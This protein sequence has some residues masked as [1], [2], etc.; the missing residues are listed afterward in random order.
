[1]SQILRQSTAVDVLIGPFLDITDGVTAE[2]GE[3]PAIK[4]SKNGQTLGAKNDATVPVH[5]ADGYHNCELDATDTDT[6]GT[7]VLTSVGTAT[8]LPI[9]HE[10]QIIHATP[11]DSI[12]GSTPTMLTSLDVG[13]LYEGAVTTPT[14]QNSFAMDTAIVSD[15]N[16][17][18]NI[19]T[20]TDITTG[21]AV[22]RY[23]TDVVQSNDT[24]TVNAIC[25]F[26]VAA[27]DILRVESRIHPGYSTSLL[28]T[29]SALN[30]VD[31]VV[32]N[33]LST[34]ST[35]AALV[36]TESIVNLVKAKTDQLSFTSG[37]VKADIRKV[38]GGSDIQAAG[39][40]SQQ[41]GES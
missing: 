34:M 22:S 6:I 32:D 1:M 41:Y 17:I 12:Y 5:D 13:Q 15:D 16:W 18:G 38:A 23:I 26:T 20:I 28:A 21:E 4:L 8:A 36:T 27:G 11:Y 39:T 35:A 25:P 37:N 33:I 14:F 31:T 3:T 9:R 24:I 2:T 7:L 40:G 30:A 29:A 10:F 19:C